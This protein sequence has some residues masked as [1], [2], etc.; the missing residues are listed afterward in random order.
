V[1][2]RFSNWSHL[3]SALSMFIALASGSGYSWQQQQDAIARIRAQEERQFQTAAN[4]WMKVPVDVRTQPDP[5]RLEHRQARDSYWDNLIGASRAL[6][7]PNAQGRPLPMVDAIVSGPEMP[8]LGDGVL[9]IGK[10]ESYRTVLSASKRSVYTEIQLRVQHFFGHPNVP[11]HEGELIDLARPGGTIVAPWGSTVSFGVHP[12]PMG[13]QPQHTYLIRLGY[14]QYGNFY[15]GGSRTGELWDLTDGTVKPGN[16][17][18]KAR[19]DHGM[20]EI[21]GLSVDALIQLLGKRY[22]DYY[23]RSR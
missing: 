8:D 7:D 3:V 10:F 4:K 16:S 23:Q 18:Q 9:L 2:M 20:S 11:I 12:E 22:Q 1:A 19:A 6:S 13:L 17:L 5:V 21:N 15:R 14:D